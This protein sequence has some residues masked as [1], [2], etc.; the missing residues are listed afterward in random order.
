M[1]AQPEASEAIVRARDLGLNFDGE[2]GT[3]NAITDIP[4]L[5]VGYQTIISGSGALDAGRGPIRTGVTAILPRG[6]AGVG[7]SC[8]A[9][10]Y[11]FN[12]NGELTGRSWIDESGSLTM[13]IA[14]SNS[15][16]VGACHQGI[17]QWVH[18]NRPDLS[19]RWLLPVVGETWDGYLNDI[20][21][22][23]VTP[24]LTAA[25]IDAATSGPLAEGSVGGGTG[26]NCYGFKGGSGTA[27]RRVDFGGQR[28][29]VAA[30]IQANFGSRSELRLDGLPLGRLSKTPNPMQQSNW[31]HIDDE[32]ARVP[33]GAGS[34]IVVIATDAPLLPNQCAA[35]AR[36]AP[37]GMART[38]TTGGHFS[39]DI[40]LAFST[41]NPG[42]LNSEFPQAETEPHKAQ[43]EFIPWG[44]IDPFYQAC[45]ETVEESIANA[46]IAA[47]DMTGRDDHFS[48]GLPH[49]EVLEAVR[50]RNSVGQE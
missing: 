30:F 45:V 13:P 7:V 34:A 41:A 38:G 9:A 17:D 33:G 20:N 18:Q 46:L 49:H 36:R 19:N 6:R 25:A 44:H 40:I 4:G 1:A 3:L 26:M 31:L 11:S 14:L 42:Q 37:L 12:G 29:H 8:S 10:T 5:E 48:P 15:H 32:R 23:H 35:L 24:E 43:L 21:G 27:S 47:Q 16:A 2:P 39:G 22:G 50:A 28:Y